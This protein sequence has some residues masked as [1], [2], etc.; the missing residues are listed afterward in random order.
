MTD[1]FSHLP[2]DARIWIYAADRDL[3]ELEE[4]RTI[5]ILQ[6]FCASWTSHGRPVPS[7]ADMLE[8]RFA[9]IAGH[10]PGGDISGC[11][12]D[13][14]VHALDRA[15]DELA[16]EWLPS[17]TVHYR[18]ANR[19]IRS[20]SRAEFR[21]SVEAGDVSEKTIVFDPGIQLLGDMR[22][23]RFGIAA[24]FSCLAPFDP[25]PPRPWRLIADSTGWT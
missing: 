23:G 17:L 22:A 20:V 13:A 14:S 10:I 21:A 18:D 5:E 3:N 1:P 24:P 25:Y 11:G 4:N 9:V 6:T 2:D 8:S 16:L 19:M 7:G 15:Q 12:V